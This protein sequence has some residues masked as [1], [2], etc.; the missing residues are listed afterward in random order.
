MAGGGQARA[1]VPLLIRPPRARSS[2]RP[3]WSYVP[4][5]QKGELPDVCKVSTPI[6]SARP[7]R[8]GTSSPRHCSK[9]DEESSTH[10]SSGSSIGAARSASSAR[11]LQTSSRSSEDGV[12]GKDMELYAET[13]VAPATW[14]PLCSRTGRLV[15]PPPPSTP[16]PPR[17]ALLSEMIQGFREA[18]PPPRREVLLELRTTHT[19]RKLDSCAPRGSRPLSWAGPG[20]AAPRRVRVDVSVGEEEI[21]VDAVVAGGKNSSNAN[22]DSASA[23]LTS[24]IRSASGDT[25][26]G[27]SDGD[28]Q[29]KGSTKKRSSSAKPPVSS[30][31]VDTSEISKVKGGKT[32]EACVRRRRDKAKDKSAAPPLPESRNRAY[33]APTKSVKAADVVAYAA[34]SCNHRSVIHV[35]DG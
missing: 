10:L 1:S 14:P 33:S 26:R 35:E 34:D 31:G 16:P 4:A 18:G 25:R 9:I 12:V 32:E 17:R 7:A 29:P 23:P 8:A 6:L 11:L 15:D 28:S 5:N 13:A 24:K 30:G 27:P 19:R 21:A 22:V 3:A 2:Q 20:P